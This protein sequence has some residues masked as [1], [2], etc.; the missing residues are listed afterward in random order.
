MVQSSE[1]ISLVLSVGVLLF[2]VQQRSNLKAIPGW[3]LLLLSFFVLFAGRVLTIVED[4]FPVDVLA[5]VLNSLEHICYAGSAVLLAWWCWHVF[6]A[7][8]G[9][10]WIRS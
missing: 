10:P 4:L 6:I 2:I 1:I 8:G 9:M 5:D 7:N 3:R